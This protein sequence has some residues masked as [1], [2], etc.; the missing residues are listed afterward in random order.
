[1]PWAL[2]LQFR[3]T[4]NCGL[5]CPRFRFF[6]KTK[7]NMLVSIAHE[8]K[9][10]VQKHIVRG[11]LRENFFR[12]RNAL[13]FIL[14]YHARSTIWGVKNTVAT[15]FFVAH[16]QLH[17]IAHQGCRITEKSHE[18]IYNVLPHPLLRREGY[19]TTTQDVKHL[20]LA[21]LRRSYTYICILWKVH[22]SKWDIQI[23]S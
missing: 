18:P 2:L 21:V 15:Q 3:I 1:M 16:T 17:F 12:K 10:H 4:G 7:E 19:K 20:M 6:V 23:L 8:K 22:Y 9:L 13:R 11:N 5:L 14:H